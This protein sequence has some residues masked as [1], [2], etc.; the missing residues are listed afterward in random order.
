MTPH[1]YSKTGI[2]APVIRA[3]ARDE[4]DISLETK[5]K[6]IM[7]ENV[8]VITNSLIRAGFMDDNVNEVEEEKNFQTA[9]RSIII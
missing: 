9:I 4:V 5:G 7:F 8:I 2:H 3:H 6:I 1:C